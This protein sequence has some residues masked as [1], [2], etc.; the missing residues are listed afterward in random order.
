M[1]RL[2]SSFANIKLKYYNKS[3]K[4]IRVTIKEAIRSSFFQPIFWFVL[5]PTH[6]EKWCVLNTRSY[7]ENNPPSFGSRDPVLFF[8][9]LEELF[10]HK[11]G[12]GWSWFFCPILPP[13]GPISVP[14]LLITSSCL[15]DCAAVLF[16]YSECFQLLVVL[17]PTTTLWAH[18]ESAFQV[19]SLGFRSQE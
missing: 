9:F 16:C 18:A 17:A 10:G 1:L 12:C 19:W 13:S 15:S 11:L 4:Q 14:L 5:G 7:S 6:E 3:Y 2:T 8:F